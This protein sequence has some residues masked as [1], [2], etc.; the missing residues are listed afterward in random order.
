M[1]RTVR[2]FVAASGAGVYVRRRVKA[3]CVCVVRV[4]VWLCVFVYVC[5]LPGALHK[6]RMECQSMVQ[7]CGTTLGYA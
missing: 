2:E 6:V 1:F 4:H 5:Y 3:V 7:V